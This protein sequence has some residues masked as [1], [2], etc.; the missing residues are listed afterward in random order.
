MLC[1][2][3]V[4][5]HESCNLNKY[6]SSDSA[7]WKAFV[8]AGGRTLS[9][10]IQWSCLTPSG[11]S[12]WPYSNLLTYTDTHTLAL[13]LT[14]QRG[15]LMRTSVWVLGGS[16]TGQHLLPLRAWALRSAW[17][18]RCGGLSSPLF[19][20]FFF[21]LHLIHLTKAGAYFL[22]EVWT[23]QWSLCIYELTVTL[24]ITVYDCIQELVMSEMRMQ[25]FHTFYSVQIS[26][27]ALRCKTRC[28]LQCHY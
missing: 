25:I 23:F 14:G 2:Y 10:I 1:Q 3:H 6:T 13:S 27:C 26:F 7:E 21:F 5:L 24:T 19:P 22:S 11:L 16:Q 18:A 15:S 4:T 20:F 17:R 9:H 12:H 28:S 8:P